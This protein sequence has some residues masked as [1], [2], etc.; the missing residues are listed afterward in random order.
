MLL[1]LLLFV[2]FFC[3][4]FLLLLLFV[5]FCFL[6]LLLLFVLFFCFFLLF[7]F[8]CL[9]FFF[10]FFRFLFSFL[11]VVVG[12]VV[13]VV[14]IDFLQRTHLKSPR[15]RRTIIRFQESFY[16]IRSQHGILTFLHLVESSGLTHWTSPI[17][18]KGCLVYLFIFYFIFIYLRKQ[19]TQQSVFSRQF[20]KVLF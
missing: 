9:F 19:E 5:C 18:F 1:L 13:V 8:F 10:L 11:F 17:L 12:V 16:S 20:L 4:L 7:V 6:L 3:L 2:L 15:L 14:V